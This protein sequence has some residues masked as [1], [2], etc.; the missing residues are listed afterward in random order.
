MKKT[1]SL[2][3]SITILI[4]CNNHT[5]F[6][7]SKADT[8][9]TWADFIIPTSWKKDS[10]NPGAYKAVIFRLA[11]DTFLFDTLNAN[12]LKK[13][14][15][16]D[17]SYFIPIVKSDTTKFYFLPKEYILKDFNKNIQ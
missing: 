13:I 17:T 8:V 1:I 10:I 3:L 12:N 4:S 2:L 15:K 16:R 5:D 11:K 7:Q 9:T 14:W 6:K